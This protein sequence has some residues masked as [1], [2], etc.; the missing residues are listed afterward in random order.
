MGVNSLFLPESR[1]TWL[2]A[3]RWAPRRTHVC[4][5]A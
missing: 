3:H 2:W 4:P 1:C 5:H